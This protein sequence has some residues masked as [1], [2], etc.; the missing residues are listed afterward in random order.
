MYCASGFSNSAGDE[1]RT[2]IKP[3]RTIY[4]K[5]IED[6]FKLGMSDAFSF[7]DM[8]PREIDG[9]FTA[10]S[11]Q[12]QQKAEHADMLAWMVG[13]YVGIAHNNPK[14]YPDKPNMIKR[15]IE[16]DEEEMP[17]DDMKDRLSAFADIH[18][19]IEGVSP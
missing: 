13:N 10:Y 5:V 9:R 11:A 16:I 15:H 6:A 14:M 3:L 8:T 4:T 17:V 1:Q 19:A 2:E 7:W 18:N 12:I